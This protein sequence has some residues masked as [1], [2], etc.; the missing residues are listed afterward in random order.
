MLLTVF[1][2]NEANCKF[3]RELIILKVEVE[4]TSVDAKILKWEYME[5]TNE[6][7]KI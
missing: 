3:L 1:E 7:Q 6:I 2:Q 5:G 4:R